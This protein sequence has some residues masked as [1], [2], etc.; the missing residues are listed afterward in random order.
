MAKPVQKQPEPQIDFSKVEADDSLTFKPQ[1]KGK[2]QK[3]IETPTEDFS[4]AINEL[5][6]KADAEEDVEDQIKRLPV[7]KQVTK[8]YLQNFH[9]DGVKGEARISLLKEIIA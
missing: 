1:R 5:F 7:S 8:D 4:T 9:K 2:Y 6:A 3:A